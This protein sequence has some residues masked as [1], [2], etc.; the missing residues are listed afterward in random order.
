MA[1]KQKNFQG[2]SSTLKHL[3]SKQSKEPKTK[4][5]FQHKNV[6]K[7]K[8]IIKPTMNKGLEIFLGLVLL[9]GAILIGWLSSAYNW[10][11][12]GRDINFLHAAWVMLQ[13]AVFWIIFFVGLLLIILGISDLKN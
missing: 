7:Q 4:H 2:N 12:A 13:G 6:F 1:G 10:T 3:L 11:I 8:T 9:V 5:I